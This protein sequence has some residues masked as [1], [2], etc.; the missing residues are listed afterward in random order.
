MI[1]TGIGS[2][3]RPVYIREVILDIMSN[4]SE[5]Y[6][7]RSGAAD[8]CDS[9]FEDMAIKKEIYLPWYG[10]N[11]SNS[12]LF[13]ENIDPTVVHYADKLI[14]HFH[15]AYHKLSPSAK[16]LHTRNVFQV[17]GKNIDTPSDLVIC[18]TENGLTKGGTATA[19]NI[20]KEFKVPVFNIGKLE[21]LVELVDAGICSNSVLNKVIS[22]Y[23]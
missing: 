18:Y 22:N 14:Q 9:D 2:R 1:V 17:L 15:P 5:T 6:T 23:D 20:A 19:I 12:N 8:G 13:L 3:K 16:K 21:H 7:L 10:F 4:L 11:G